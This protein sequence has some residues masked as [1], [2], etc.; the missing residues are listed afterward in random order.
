MKNERKKEIVLLLDYNQRFSYKWA[1]VPYKSGMDKPLLKKEFEKYNCSILF[2]N[3]TDIDFR[4]RSFFENKVFL[5]TSSEDKNLFYKS[6]IEDI[7]LGLELCGA[8]VIP[9]YKYLRAHHNKTFMEIFRDISK[10]SGIKNIQSKHFGTF[11]EFRKIAFKL[12]YP[13]VLKSAFGATSKAVTLIKNESEAFKKVK[14]F[15]KS[16]NLWY[17]FKDCVRSLKHKGYIKE[18][19]YR[20]KF[21]VQNFLP[22]MDRDYKILVFDYKFYVLER[23]AKKNDFRAS[24]S[25]IIN[26]TKNLPEGMLDF[27]DKFFKYVDLPF[28][29]MDIGNNGKAFILI[30]FQ[31][32]YFGTHA[33]DTA[34]YYFQK[35]DKKWICVEEKSTLEKEI[36]TSVV[37]Y[38][39]KCKK[40]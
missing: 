25:G 32:L 1:A 13:L 40:Y 6:Y 18:S 23:R 30:E 39:K 37:S 11:E 19:R 2:I 26:Y 14:Y 38:L 9:S 15:S 36:A 28:L 4:N 20:R 33:I 24:G 3:Y 34:P 17:D 31:A 29:A 10:F 16:K 22:D 21:L 8:E 35:K 27:A 7:V 5:Y 12:R